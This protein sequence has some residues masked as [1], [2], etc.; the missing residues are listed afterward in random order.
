MRRDPDMQKK[1]E[2]SRDNAID[3]LHQNKKY[4]VTVIRMSIT[5]GF[6]HLR[7]HEQRCPFLG[8]GINID[9]LAHFDGYLHND[10]PHQFRVGKLDPA[11]HNLQEAWKI[12]SEDETFSLVCEEIWFCE[13]G[14][15]SDRT[16]E[17][18]GD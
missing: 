17:E 6:A 9:N 4:F 18:C 3:R 1:L 2:V 15:N 13:E 7:F 10:G 8:F 11:T 14:T 5:H 16:N 12:S